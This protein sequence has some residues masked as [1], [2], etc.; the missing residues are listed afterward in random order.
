[1]L[2]NFE[3]KIELK[4]LNFINEGSYHPLFSLNNDKFDNLFKVLL[5]IPEIINKK[6][7]YTKTEYENYSLEFNNKEIKLKKF[8]IKILFNKL[9]FSNI[10]NIPASYLTMDIYDI[11]NNINLSEDLINE[12]LKYSG[13]NTSIHSL[14]GIRRNKFIV[15]NNNKMNLIC[16]SKNKKIIT[17]IFYQ[18]FLHEYIHLFENY[19]RVKNN[20]NNELILM[21]K[22]IDEKLNNIKKYISEDEYNALDE[23]MYRLYLGEESAKIGNLFGFLIKNNITDKYNFSYIK[24]NSSYFKQYNNLKNC[25][26]IINKI[27]NDIFLE[28][29]GISKRRLTKNIIR[30]LENYYEKGIKFIGRYFMLFS[31]KTFLYEEYL[32]NNH[33]LKIK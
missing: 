16:F 23:L 28:Y 7:K 33:C 30:R 10:I 31:N 17:D 18:I 12:L 27:S 32:T 25:L 4:Y 21:K 11:P 15:G 5:N 13:G 9:G 26:I 3:R 6:L 19:L 29:F 22:N 14:D 24:N 8:N 1:M 2:E 20:K